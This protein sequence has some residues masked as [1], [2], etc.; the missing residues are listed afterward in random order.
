MKYYILLFCIL[1]VGCTAAP[2][3]TPQTEPP[4]VGGPCEYVSTLGQC[5]ISAVEST[6]VTF[7]FIPDGSLNLE[8]ADWATEDAILSKQY[9]QDVTNPNFQLGESVACKIKLITKGT[10]TPV[11]FETQ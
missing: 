6:S 10:C 2:K 9:T 7:S 5:S 11:L 8:G 1:L 3:E 4:I